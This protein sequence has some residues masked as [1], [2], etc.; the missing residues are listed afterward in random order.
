MGFMA[1]KKVA[2]LWTTVY[3]PT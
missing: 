3:T 1:Q 2:L